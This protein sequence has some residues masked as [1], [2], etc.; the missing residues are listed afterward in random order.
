M[1]GLFP[2]LSLVIIISLVIYFLSRKRKPL[3]LPAEGVIRDILQAHV[4]FYQQLDETHKA[5]FEKRVN[6]FLREIRITGVK[7]TVEDQ[8]KVFAAASAII[9]VFAFERWQYR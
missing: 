2:L 5:A 1:E 6:N 9:P 4:R 3:E 8:D 7:T